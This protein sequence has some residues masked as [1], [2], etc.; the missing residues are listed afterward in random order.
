M[1]KKEKLYC[2]LCCKEIIDYYLTDK[3]IKF[4][5]HVDCMEIYNKKIFDKKHNITFYCSHKDMIK[6]LNA[7]EMNESEDLD[8]L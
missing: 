2:K 4:K 8:I 5:F 1:I 3:N 6:T 7:L